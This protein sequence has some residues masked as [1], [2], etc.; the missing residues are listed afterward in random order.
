MFGHGSQGDKKC[1]HECNSLVKLKMVNCLK[2]N[3]KQNYKEEE[4]LRQGTWWLF[5]NDVAQDLNQTD[6]FCE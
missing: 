5:G 6:Q 1:S 3:V 4:Y 2:S